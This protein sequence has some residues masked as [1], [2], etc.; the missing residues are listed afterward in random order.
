M[1]V[2][3][4]CRLFDPHTDEI[5]ENVS[6][7]V[8]GGK[9]EPVD[10]G[11]VFEIYFDGEKPEFAEKVI[12]EIDLENRLIIPCFIDAHMHCE[13]TLLPPSHT[14]CI[15]DC[16]TAVCIADPH[17]IVN[18]LGKQG[19]ELFLE[20]AERAV[21]DFKFTI[22]SC[23]PATPFETAGGNVTSDLV[24]ELLKSDCERA[25]A[26]EKKAKFYANAKRIAGLA[27]VMNVP[28]VLDD[29][30][31]K[32]QGIL[33][34]SRSAQTHID[35]HAPGVSVPCLNRYIAAGIT[36]DHECTTPHELKER[37]RRGMNVLI[38]EGTVCHNAR[39]L[40]TAL[41]AL[42]KMATKRC[43]FCTD[44]RRV[45]DILAIGHI[46]N[47]VKIGMECGIDPK[48]AVRMATLN[49]AEMFNLS[50]D[51]GSIAPGKYASFIVL[52]GELRE[53]EIDR[54]YI[55]GSQLS[56]SK[57]FPPVRRLNQMNVDLEVFHSALG[58]ATFTGPAIGVIPNQVL[59][60]EEEPNA[61]SLMLIVVERYTGKSGMGHC[62]VNGIPL[63]KECAVASTVSHDSHNV[64]CVGSSK[65]AIERAVRK[66]VEI[67]GG[68]VC[69]NNDSVEVLPLPIGGLVTD[70]PVDELLVTIKRFHEALTQ[71]GA[72][73]DFDIMM[74]LSALCLPVIPKLRLTDNGLFDVDAFQFVAARKSV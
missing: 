3:R 56:K 19:F 54:V 64:V 29:G 4:N 62:L 53:L 43:A 23:V 49:P 67:G 9:S 26:I 28:G 44:D 68:Y 15:A 7:S 66:I 34:E 27:E 37:I 12:E 16:G 17:E 48:D 60:T 31:D 14:S 42:P 45:E 69:V 20:D 22:P 2:F 52:K 10:N 72:G 61:E 18:V 13:S 41:A 70:E 39:D 71:A 57:E 50:S 51:Y 46:D 21:V 38:R 36:T 59:T 55:K 65:T 32:L 24:A 8:T 11:R 33:H 5:L 58:K 73:G 6:F 35:G 1:R 74:T 47:A 63:H 25:A 40:C 30:F